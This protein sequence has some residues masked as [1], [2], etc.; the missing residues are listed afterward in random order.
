MEYFEYIK[1]LNLNIVSI[2]YNTYVHLH[3]MDCSF[4]N[5]TFINFNFNAYIIMNKRNSVQ[6]DTC[7]RVL[8]TV[9]HSL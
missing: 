8:V 5:N 3:E 1:I 7:K 6:E 2:W 4:E 9:L